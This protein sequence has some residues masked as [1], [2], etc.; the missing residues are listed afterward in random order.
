[1]KNRTSIFLMLTLAIS[2]IAAGCTASASV[3]KNIQTKPQS[4]Q[5]GR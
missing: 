1:M 4:A 5:P 2:L 3:G